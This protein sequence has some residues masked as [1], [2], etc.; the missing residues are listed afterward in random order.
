MTTGT[1]PWRSLA[2][3]AAA[4]KSGA[5]SP[6]ELTRACLERIEHVEA[7]VH[8]FVSVDA[9]GAMQAARAAEQAI[10]A[11]RSPL[12][13]ARGSSPTGCRRATRPR[14]LG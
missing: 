13:T 1:W 7:V 14:A 8:A 9:D 11:G 3:A 5:V 4:V 12:A 6:V 10:K 2:E